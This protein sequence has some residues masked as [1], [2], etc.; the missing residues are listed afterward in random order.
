MATLFK[1]DKKKF[2][3][4]IN[5]GNMCKDTGKIIPVEYILYDTKKV[6]SDV[7]IQR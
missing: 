7:G 5:Q 3:P 4:L 2:L 1:F 6:N